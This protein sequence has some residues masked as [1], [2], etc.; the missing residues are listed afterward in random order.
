MLVGVRRAGP[1]DA[2]AIAG[3]HVRAWQVAY[4]GLV[5]D[6]IL[7]AMSVPARE[8]RWDAIL[9]R[10]NA[11]RYT[12]VAARGPLVIGFCSIIAP[13]RDADAGARTAEVAAVYVEPDR[14]RTGTGSAL[15]RA[16]LQALRDDGWHDVTL[17][18]F[19]DNVGAR[20]FYER[21]GFA[22]DGREEL[23]TRTGQQMIRLLSGAAAL[24]GPADSDPR[25]RSRPLAS[26]RWLRC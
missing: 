13:S 11:S 26:A 16:A 7:D 23:D 5:P 19:A 6:A 21:F 14:W 4:R 3:V 20:T 18:V 9:R 12:F 8:A 24:A 10:D 15:L 22:P 17:W 1:A 25:Q 2:A